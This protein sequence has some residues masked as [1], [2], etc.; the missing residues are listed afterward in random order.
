M[1]VSGVFDFQVEFLKNNLRLEIG[2]G[3]MS[4]VYGSLDNWGVGFG[5]QDMNGKL[6]TFDLE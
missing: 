3:E 2:G 4:L 1:R 5:M 6:S